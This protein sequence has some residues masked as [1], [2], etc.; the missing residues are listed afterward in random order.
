MDNLN[1][2]SSGQ[3]VLNEQ[4]LPKNCVLLIVD[5][6]VKV[7]PLHDFGIIEIKTHQGKIKQIAHTENL[8][9]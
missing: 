5:G 3:L 1:F 6:K 7:Q 8:Q 2:N 4:E 9:F